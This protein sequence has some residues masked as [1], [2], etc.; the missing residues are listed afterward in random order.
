MFF[1]QK[2]LI[3]TCEIYIVK[4]LIVIFLL[5]I[6]TTL[7]SFVFSFPSSMRVVIDL[8]KEFEINIPT[9]GKYPP[10]ISFY[11]FNSSTPLCLLPGCDIHSDVIQVNYD[12]KGVGFQGTIFAAIDNNTK[13]RESR[14]MD[15][16]SQSGYIKS[17]RD[18]DDLENV[19]NTTFVT[20]GDLNIKG[21]LEN[22]TE[23]TNSYIF[24]S[25]MLN[26]DNN[27]YVLDVYFKPPEA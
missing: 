11:E 9:G 8:G 18:Y 13:D 4:A 12:E 3:Y 27:K 14:A 22:G 21:M 24:N 20:R 25:S 10:T 17:F 23:W 15:I 26:F 6:V 16:S 19:S 7:P 2:V 5:L 1:G